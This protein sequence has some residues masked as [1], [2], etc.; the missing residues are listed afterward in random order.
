LLL[1]VVWR[2]S[3]WCGGG[4]AGSAGA[5]GAP[6]QAVE[7]PAAAG[8]GDP[9]EPRPAGDAQPGADLGLGGPLLVPA[10]DA[11]P[12]ADLGGRD[13]LVRHRLLLRTGVGGDEPR[14]AVVEGEIGPRGAGGR[15]GPGGPLE[16][17][18]VEYDDLVV[19]EGPDVAV[20]AGDE[21][22]D[23]RH[24]GWGG[25]DAVQLAGGDVEP[26]QIDC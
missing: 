9:R 23:V 18:R 8:G 14:A 2:R 13:D 4:R 10:G 12:G 7:A 21:G 16:G 5:A 20:G 15:D 24:P 26:D 6:A 1:W 17:V 19:D 11:Q 3:R 25:V 22:G